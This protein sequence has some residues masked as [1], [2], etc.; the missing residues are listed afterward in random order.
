M[1][2][3]IL[4]SFKTIITYIVCWLAIGAIQSMIIYF[5]YS[6][7]L[8]SSLVDGFI[9]N[10]SFA[11]LGIGIWF[12]TR[13]SKPV[14]HKLFNLLFNQLTTVVIVLFLWLIFNI[15]VLQYLFF[16]NAEYITFLTK[17]I[18][19][20]VISGLFYYSILVL[21]YYLL[22][23]YTDLQDKL[24]NEL[25]LKEMVKEAELNMLKSQINP[26]F[27][28][29]SLNSISSLTL[30]NPEKAQEMIIKLSDFLRYS[31]SQP[32]DKF[33][34]LEN[35]FN[36]ISRYLDI[37]KIRFGNKL[38]YH[39]QLT[40]ESLSVRIPVMIL[41]PIYENAVKH[42]V[43]ESIDTVTIHTA[44]S[45]I[46]DM[47]IITIINNFEEHSKY[48]KSSGIGLKNIRERLKLIYQNDSLLKTNFENNK[49]KVELTIPIEK[50]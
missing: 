8:S 31:V 49:F 7:L 17:S 46:H 36:N 19:W 21:I 26:H 20:R 35:E 4:K 5:N 16:E 18:P 44:T 40:P 14:K 39:Y 22:I 48:Q 43:Y 13:Y 28:F 50:Q 27:L 23:Y 42:G 41:Q 1:D 11:G 33:T 34:T 37:E 38:V 2:H 3:P 15:S 29:N 45:L 24:T 12:P 30:T 6:Q 10:F 47:L 9:F 25:R 32:D